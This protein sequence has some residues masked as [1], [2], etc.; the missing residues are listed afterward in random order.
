MVI[1]LSKKA[2]KNYKKLPKTIRTKADKKLNLLLKNYRDPSLYTKKM[3]GKDL[4]E[5]RIDIRYRIT[6][7]E[8]RNIIYIINLGPHDEGLGKK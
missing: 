3:S 4:F 1:R 2:E 7:Y 5:A 8:E 6:F